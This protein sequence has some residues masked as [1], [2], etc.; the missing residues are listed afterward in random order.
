MPALADKWRTI[1]PDF[2]GFGY[3]EAPADF[4]YSFDSPTDE[5]RDELAKAVSEEP[6]YRPPTYTS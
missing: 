1:A 3:S 5:R 2:P 4:E 6:T